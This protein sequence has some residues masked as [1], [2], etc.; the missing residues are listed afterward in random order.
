MTLKN[1]IF[2]WGFLATQTALILAAMVF[3]AL[4][5]FNK[6]GSAYE[7]LGLAILYFAAFAILIVLNFIIVNKMRWRYRYYYRLLHDSLRSKLL[8]IDTEFNAGN[9]SED[10]AEKERH[11]AGLMH[12]LAGRLECFCVFIKIFVCVMTLLAIAAVVANQILLGKLSFSV[13]YI[14]SASFIAVQTVSLPMFA[15]VHQMCLFAE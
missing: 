14:Q 15:R 1:K 6:I 8:S 3:A 10:D 5:L 13:M 2:G 12:D 9:L 11:Y 7:R 4:P